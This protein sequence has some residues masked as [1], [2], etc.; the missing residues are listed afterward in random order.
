MRGRAYRLQFRLVTR[1][2]WSLL[3]ALSAA[4]FL[5]VLVDASLESNW[6][7]LASLASL[8][9]SIAGIRVLWGASII[10][11]PDGLRVYRPWWPLHR[12]IDWYRILATDIIP[13]FW[14]LELEMNS[15][16]RLELPSVEHM[17]ELYQQIEDFRTRL[18]SV[19]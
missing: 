13:G 17:D 18:D 3:L 4:F 14:F 15:G 6:F 10:A 8:L 7:R 2:V 11:G 1:V 9:C 12:D 19:H 5:R 16:E